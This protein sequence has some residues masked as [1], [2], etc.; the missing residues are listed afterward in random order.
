[1]NS[2][3]AS[4]ITSRGFSITGKQSQERFMGLKLDHIREKILSENSHDIG[5]GLPSEVHS[6][7]HEVFDNVQPVPHIE[8]VV[9]T[10]KQEAIP[11]C[12]ASS[13]PHEKMHMTLGNSG[14]LHLFESVLYSSTQVSRGKPHPDLFQLAASEMGFAVEKCVVI[15][16]SLPGV[17][18]ARAAGIRVLGYVADPLSRKDEML[19][20]GAELFH[21]MREVPSLLGLED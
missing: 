14:L 10:L 5:D 17:L 2:L 21:D 8:S 4:V 20:N 6:R 11:Y 7:I 9:Q 19:F 13:G 16:D 1:M 18:A 3:I 15:E 12:V